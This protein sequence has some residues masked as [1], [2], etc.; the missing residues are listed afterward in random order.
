MHKLQS[1][2]RGR[3]LNRSWEQS[4]DEATNA[5]KQLQSENPKEDVPPAQALL[6]YI[7]KGPLWLLTNFIS[8]YEHTYTCRQA[9]NPQAMLNHANPALPQWPLF[10]VMVTTQAPLTLLLTATHAA[11]GLRRAHL[12]AL[13]RWHS[14][15]ACVGDSKRVKARPATRLSLS[16]ESC[17][18]AV[19]FSHQSPCN[20]RW[21]ECP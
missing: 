10:K 8:K 20:I 2:L 3:A 1:K 16:S 7:C 11:P 6:K 13:D 17:P 14:L 9:G 4:S 5:S 18:S 15:S 12:S 21:D 19:V